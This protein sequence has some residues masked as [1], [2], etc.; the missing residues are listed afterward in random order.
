MKRTFSIPSEIMAQ[1]PVNGVN[2]DVGTS[3]RVCGF[4]YQEL[5]LFLEHRNRVVRHDNENGKFAAYNIAADEARNGNRQISADALKLRAQRIR[6]PSG[7]SMRKA[8]KIAVVLVLVV[9]AFGRR[10]ALLSG[11]E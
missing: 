6:K 2:A 10:I 3:L 7:G 1:V 9:D 8:V 5:P 11:N 4:T